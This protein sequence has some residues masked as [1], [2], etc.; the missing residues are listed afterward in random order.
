MMSEATV[1]VIDDDDEVRRALVFLLAS[2]GIEA[3]AHASAND[4]LTGFPRGSGGCIVT[5]V[6]MPE[7]TGIDLLKQLKHEDVRVPVI[8]MTGDGDI[9]LAVEAMKI[10]ALDFLEKP[11]DDELFIMSVRRALDMAKKAG[12]L[13]A[14][15][16]CFRDRF[17]TLSGRERDVFNGLIAG[18]PN[19]IIAHLH[20]ISPKTVEVYRANVMD[21]MKASSLSELVRIAMII[22]PPHEGDGKPS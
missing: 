13:D 10:G 18:H 5:D 7:M 9:P 20:G 12:R 11:F 4:F 2:V 21:K 19:K 1:H 17:E 15:R 22:N 6:R 3:Q 8:V 14:E 16:R